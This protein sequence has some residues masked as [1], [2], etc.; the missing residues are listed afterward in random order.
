V[1]TVD[2]SYDLV[3]LR[4]R[5]GDLRESLLAAERARAAQIAAVHPSHRRSAINLVHYVE[6]RNH[7]I[8]GLQTDLALVGLSSLGR[9]EP[10]V[11]ATIEAVLS[12]LAIMT[13]QAPPE[14]HATIA[15]TE[16]HDL[17]ELNA[18]RLLGPARAGR[19]TRIMVTMPADAAD[20]ELLIER[21]LAGG[22]DVARVN[23]AHDD[24]QVWSRLISRLRSRATANGR[25]LRIAMDLGGPKLRTGRLTAGPRA[26]RVGPRRDHCGRITSPGRIRLSVSAEASASIPPLSGDRD[27]VNVPVSDSA[28]LQRRQAGDPIE[29]VDGRGAR[30]HWEVTSVDAGGCIASTTQTSYVVTGL[31]LVCPTTEGHDVASVG[32]LPEIEQVHRVH[33]GDSIVLTRSLEPATPTPGGSPHFIGCT[34]PEAF[35]GARTGERVWLDDGK[36]G[37]TIHDVAEDRI[38]LIVTDVRPGGANLKAG[39]GIN[40]PDTELQLRALTPT[41]LEAL[42]FVARHA[43]I[44]NLS[45]VRRP[46][47]VEQLQAEL[48][49]RGAGDIGIV[50]KIENVAAFENLPELLLTAMR[51]PRLGVMIAR[52]DLAVEVGFE[53]LAEVQEEIMWACEAG[54][55][56][57]IWATQV[58]DTLAR[59]G[60][61][62]RAEVTDAA[63]SERAECVM[64]NKGPYI[65]EAIAALD[66]ILTRMHDHQDKKRSLL[67]R[68]RSWEPKAEQA[69]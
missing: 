27:I 48:Q 13:D 46:Q 10:Y 67:R 64:L 51:S 21:W 6:L 17:L 19:S 26:V 61:A 1:L 52:G 34:L 14:R 35:R 55:V 9:S 24:P 44:V 54:H 49:Q 47:D 15:L 16:G 58:L 36:I 33:R 23:C 7:D 59:T 11:M 30:R 45:F 28:W 57:V 65:T 8:R 22:M 69:R 2:D 29:L 25:S 66:S 4:Q 63:M 32:L 38:E 42:T 18:D 50:L 12:L 31:E 62:T 5:V 3:A 40:L 20:D 68:L 41:D 43:D 56:P 37:G 53:R 39:K 60:R